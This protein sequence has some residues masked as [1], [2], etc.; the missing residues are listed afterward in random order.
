[1][2]VL[3]VSGA[4]SEGVLRRLEKLGVTS[5][6]MQVGDKSELLTKYMLEQDISKEEVLYMGDDMPDYQVMKLAGLACA[7]ADGMPE[8]KTIAHYITVKNGGEGCVREV[9]EKVLKIN[10]HWET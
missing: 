2:R 10:S 3:V 1:Y 5:V 6:F 4:Y 9:I 8:I 7:P